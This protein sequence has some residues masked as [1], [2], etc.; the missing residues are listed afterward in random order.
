MSSATLKGNT[1]SLVPCQGNKAL[2]LEIVFPNCLDGLDR[3]TAS[4]KLIEF[5]FQRERTVEFRFRN[6]TIKLFPHADEGPFTAD[7][8][9]ILL[10][11]F[12]CEEVPENLTIASSS[13]LGHQEIGIVQ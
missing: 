1:A 8:I 13:P 4:A 11:I 12:K 9:G 6:N 10:D 7:H 3:R 5:S 2:A